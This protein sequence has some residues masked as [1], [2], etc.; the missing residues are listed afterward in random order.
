M[1]ALQSTVCAVP[2]IAGLSDPIEARRVLTGYVTEYRFHA[3]ESEV[4]ETCRDFDNGTVEFVGGSGTLSVGVLSRPLRGRMRRHVKVNQST[5]VMFD[6]VLVS[7][8]HG[9][10]RRCINVWISGEICLHGDR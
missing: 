10:H 9:N 8:R 7:P 5:T 6:D 4:N 3:D 2:Y 1:K